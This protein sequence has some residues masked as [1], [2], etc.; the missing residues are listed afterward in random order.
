MQ[1]I[2]LVSSSVLAFVSCSA[3]LAQPKRVEAESAR[4]AARATPAATA[5]KP[6]PQAVGG[7]TSTAQDSGA[8]KR[9]FEI[10]DFY[11]CAV[12][13][14]PSLSRD[15]ARVAFGVR[16]YELEAGKT[17]SEVWMMAAD[18]TNLRQMT[19]G[20]HNDTDPRFSPDGKR[21]L[22]ASDRGGSAQV[23]VM[24]VDGGEPMQ[25]TKFGPGVG[26]PEWS[27]DGKYIAVTADVYPECGI[28]EKCNARIA[29]AREKGKLKAHVTDELLYRHW[30]GWR[31]GTRTHILL[32]DAESGK[33]TK[34]MTPGPWESPTF[35][36]GGRGFSFSP[37][38][39]ELCYVSNH[40][41]DEASS[42]NADLWTVPVDGTIDEKTAVNLTAG[43]KGWDS[44]PLY[45]PDGKWIAYISQETPGYES[46]LKRLALY[47]REN[48]ARGYLTD[49]GNFNNWVNDMRWSGDSKSLVFQAECAGRT[50]LYRIQIADGKP[51]GLL[52]PVLWH[53][54]IGGFELTPDGS[55]VLYTRK[56]INEPSEVFRSGFDTTETKTSEF[57]P[58]DVSVSSSGFPGGSECDPK[59]RG[60]L[61]TSF[62]YSVP[63]PNG[64]VRL[65]EFNQSIESEVDIR[66]PEELSFQGD[67]DYKV[68]CFL[69]KP[70]GFDPAKKYPLILNVHGGPQSQWA[71][72][73]RG[74]WQV[75]PGKGYVVAFCNPTGSTGYGQDLTDGIAGDWGGRVYRDLMKVTDELEKLPYVDKN[76]M[77]LMGWS[78]GGYMTMWMQGHTTRFQCIASMMGVY[79]LEAEYGSTEELWFPEHDF[80]GMPWTSEDYAKWSPCKFVKNFKTP[81]LVIT[82]EKDYRVPYTQSLEYYTGLKKMGVPARLI[83]YPNAGHWPSWYEMALY[84][85]AHLEFFHQYLGGEPAPWKVEDFGNNLAFEKKSAKKEEKAIN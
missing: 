25:L 79:D 72:S 81:A 70:H 58:V 56:S 51:G 34:D 84:Y 1:R 40:D 45:S 27:P 29:D 24:P 26:G 59:I 66:P 6:A 10:A 15:G 67:G 41:A 64:R 7:T 62:H 60:F 52:A 14:A 13:S 68:H 83:V 2:A 42:T 16:R 74:D 54:F 78:Y 80:K 75:Y 61:R 21:L 19:S 37:D 77:G 71:D 33:V 50:P 35:S 12:V 9:A 31:D 44:E 39:K 49:R 36:L 85:D 46:A 76:K 17:R 63:T 55:G 11:R 18:G 8:G 5:A 23:W 48:K 47:N 32:V 82:G 57:A 30:T 69:V 4:P 22:F 20:E 43:N 3:P 73:F 38:G 53:A 28:D 65:T